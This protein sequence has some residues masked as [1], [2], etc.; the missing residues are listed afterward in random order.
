MQEKLLMKHYCKKKYKDVG[1]KSWVAT[2]FCRNKGVN[3][4]VLGS[5]KGALGR[6][7]ILDG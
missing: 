6:C 4:H 2:K 7:W 3:V 1:F 5:L